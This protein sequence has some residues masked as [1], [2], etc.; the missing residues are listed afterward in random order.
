MRRVKWC[1][2]GD[3]FTYLNDHLDETGYR[4]TRGYMD[5][6]CDQFDNLDV[7][8][9]GINGSV[10]GDWVNVPLPEADIYTILLGTNDWHR[11]VMLGTAEDFAARREGTILGNLGIIIGNIEAKAPQAKILV[12]NPIE[13]SD[14]VYIADML[15]HAVGSYAPE[16]GQYLRQVAEGIVETA[17]A[18]G[19]AVVN[20]H[21]LT[22]IT[23]ENA[24]KGKYLKGEDGT[25]RMVPYPDYIGLPMDY[26]KDA[27]PYPPEAAEM[28]YD[29][30]HPSDKGNAVIAAL[31]AEAMAQLPDTGLVRH[32]GR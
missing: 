25:Y 14:F 15:N 27:Y 24:L 9:I 29:G 19:Y 31:M 17:A 20:L 18:A 8:N 21:R 12:A 2:I 13:R 23:V 26:E 7:I 3:S 11:Q 16:A 30:L 10:T 5:R 6:I 28:T 4:V 22:G 1:A 32:Y